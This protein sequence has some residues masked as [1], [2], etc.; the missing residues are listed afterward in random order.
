MRKFWKIT[1]LSSIIFISPPTLA[2][3]NE[4]IPLCVCEDDDNII[5]VENVGEKEYHRLEKYENDL[6]CMLFSSN[7]VDDR[8]KIDI[9]I[10]TRDSET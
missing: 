4:E 10:C 6:L 7:R 9:A 2:N 3:F 8:F 5:L 1:V